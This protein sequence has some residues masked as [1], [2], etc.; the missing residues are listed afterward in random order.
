MDQFQSI[1]VISSNEN[2]LEKFIV[3]FLAKLDIKNS[4]NNPDIVYIDQLSGWGIDQIRFINKLVTTPPIKSKNRLIIIKDSQNLNIESQNSLLK[5]LE[6]PPYHTF[7]LLSTTNLNLL[8]DTIKSRCLIVKSPYSKIS[9]QKGLTI[10]SNLSQNL[11]YSTQISADKK[12]LISLIQNQIRLFHDELL[13]NP[14]P[15]I[16]QNI[17]LLH[18]S[19]AMIDSNVNPTSALD[20]FYLSLS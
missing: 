10:T 16:S 9:D 8:L 11:A 15:K 3:S 14:N 2:F 17:K 13:N 5:T 7:F 4:P 12:N 1:I 6:E 18:K 20:F 19:L